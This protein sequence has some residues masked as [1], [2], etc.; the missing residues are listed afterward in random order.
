MH[1]TR[2]FFASVSTL[3]LYHS[4]IGLAIVISLNQ[5]NV[6]YRWC[7]TTLKLV[8]MNAFVH[9]TIGFICGII[10]ITNICNKRFT[11]D[12]LTNLAVIVACIC[13]L[14]AVYIY[15]TLPDICVEIFTVCY[16]HVLI[17]IYYEVI[18]TI[19]FIGI[20]II[21]LIILSCMWLV[22]RKLRV[23]V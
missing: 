15:W 6:Q 5:V 10:M 11:C 3:G 2:K 17:F 4:I 14:I 22:Y 9:I 1:D 18:A 20:L 8:Y 7:T 12:L 23:S 21:A 19:T 16:E 13:H